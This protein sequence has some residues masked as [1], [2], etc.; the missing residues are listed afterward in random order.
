MATATRVAPE[1]ASGRNHKDYYDI[2]ILGKTGMGKT[3]TADK[4]LLANP[5]EEG[6]EYDATVEDSPTTHLIAPNGAQDQ[7]KDGHATPSQPSTGSST[8]SE[9]TNEVVSTIK[10]ATQ[11]NDLSMWHL[12]REQDVEKVTKRLKDLVFWRSLGDPHISINKN[13]ESSGTTKSCQLLSNDTS[14]IRVLDV[15][16]FY[17]PDDDDSDSDSEHPP[18]LNEPLESP[19]SSIFNIHGA[20]LDTDLAI[21]RKILHIKVATNFQFNRI[22]YFLPDT[23][24]LVRTSRNLKTEL[25]VME[26]YFKR[27]VFESMVVVA[28]QNRSIYDKLREGCEIFTED[29]IKKTRT[30]FKKAMRKVFQGSDAPNPPIIFISLKDSCDEIL[31]KIKDCVVIKEGVGLTF[32]PSTCARCGIHIGKLA[33]PNDVKEVERISD[34]AIAVNDPGSVAIPY[35]ESTCHPRF[36]PR[37]SKVKCIVGGI[38]HLITLKQFIGN[39][40]YFGNEDE[41]CINCNK[42]PKSRGCVRVGTK[43][44]HKKAKD[45]ITVDHTS[46]IDEN[47]V[48]VLEA[49]DS[50]LRMRYGSERTDSQGDESYTSEP[51][52]PAITP[53]KKLQQKLPDIE[54]TK[55]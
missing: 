54:N 26:R 31:H 16:G 30:I 35:D 22:V 44:V 34:I 3:T 7:E 39:W 1:P 40:P 46:D 52:S 17:G 37:Y 6:Y 53:T 10:A 24:V 5:T 12:S 4:L 42:P 47:Y 20:G 11:Y 23:G 14:K 43:F 29:E 9:D 50:V 41:V 19:E 55:T 25:R 21:M 33:D 8:A 45:G 18:E 32:N 49:Q 2:M 48:F 38:V 36:I 27:T 51:E 28:T 15:P 13:R